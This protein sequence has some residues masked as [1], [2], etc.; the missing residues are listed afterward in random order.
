MYHRIWMPWN[1]KQKLPLPLFPP[2]SVQPINLQRGSRLDN[3]SAAPNHIY[4]QNICFPRSPRLRQADAIFSFFAEE[5]YWSG[6]YIRDLEVNNPNNYSR[7]SCSRLAAYQLP[8]DHS[9]EGPP[10]SDGSAGQNKHAWAGVTLL[11]ESYLFYSMFIFSA[12]I[13]TI[14]KRINA[15]LV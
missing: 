9:C 15:I 12:T 1:A 11:E 5:T 6:W 10:A 4:P 8:V 2:P 14:F 3:Q 7:S 13:D